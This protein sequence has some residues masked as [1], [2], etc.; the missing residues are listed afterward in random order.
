[1]GNRQASQQ[2]PIQQS[3]HH[4]SLSKL[5]EVR[6]TDNQGLMLEFKAATERIRSAEKNWKGHV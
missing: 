5:F 6:L 1:M 4:E 3:P 2:E